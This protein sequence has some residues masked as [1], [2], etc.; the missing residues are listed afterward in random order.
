MQLVKD[1]LIYRFPMITEDRQIQAMDGNLQ[2]SG[3]KTVVS[4]PFE[5]TFYKNV[6][7]ED[8]LIYF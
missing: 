5:P 2:S 6:N 4:G 1:F 3:L 8:M 7:L